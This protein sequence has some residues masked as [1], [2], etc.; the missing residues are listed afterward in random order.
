MG[1]AEAAAEESSTD[2]SSLRK[3]EVF[4]E[5]EVCPSLYS[6]NRKCKLERKGVCEGNSQ[7]NGSLFVLG[8]WR[9]N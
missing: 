5:L 8:F 3:R 2:S 9:L 7:V 4:M 1:L 6:L